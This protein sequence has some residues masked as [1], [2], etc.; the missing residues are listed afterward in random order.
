MRV[1]RGFPPAAAIAGLIVLLW[2]SGAPSAQPKKAITHDVYDSWKSIQGTRL[3]S[4]GV[5]LAYALVPQDGD[6]ELVVRNLKTNA[7]IRAPRGRDPLITTDGKFVV[8]ALAPLKKDMDA[9]RK[10]KKKP[11]EMP[12]NGVGFV[13]LSTGQVTSLAEH[14]ESFRVAEE[15][16]Q[17]VVYLTVPAPAA[18]S[19]PDQ[20]RKREKKEPG[21]D[22]VIRDLYNG[23]QT[24]VA[25]VSDYAM[26]RNGAWLLYA[27]SSKTPA[28]D[29]AFVRGLGN[30]VRKTL[31]AGPGN[32]KAF[33]FDT[34]GRQAA[35]VSDRDDFTSA[36]PRFKL[37]QW[38]TTADTATEL[39]TPS[40]NGMTVSDN[41]RLEFSKDAARLFVGT[42]PSRVPDPDDSSDLV[43]VDIWHYKDAELQPMQKVRADAERK[44]TFRCVYHLAAKKF[45]QLAT[46]DMPDGRAGENA[47]TALGVSN[48]PYRQ[49]S[50]WDGNYD[51]YYLVS[52][53]DG[54]RKK[55]LDKERFGA[56]LSP[57]GTFALFFDA[58]DDNWYAIRLSDGQ[59]TNLTKGL[60]VKFQSETDDHPD[61]PSPYGQAGWTEGD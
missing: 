58:D 35:F 33:V 10:A 43:S 38:S 26:T 24:S 46:P 60:G 22:L 2:L 54:T 4:D 3:S 29:G 36:V 55:I 31:L 19:K 53:T 56:T 6:G 48:V 49:M 37:Y 32:Y 51:D 34:N 17:V 20:P 18:E 27:V 57:G 45:A 13:N 14:V 16:P 50:S 40:S 61:H 47:P 8:F 9:A 30:G 23:A 28:N 1:R 7:E 12:K 21:T 59:K 25:E 11:E 41:G 52:L 44:R 39:P 5:W 15:T 42:A